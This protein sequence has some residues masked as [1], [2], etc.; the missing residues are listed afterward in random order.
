MRLVTENLQAIV[1]TT[2]IYFALPSFDILRVVKPWK[3]GDKF[4]DE[5]ERLIGGGVRIAGRIRG[6][7]IE[8]DLEVVVGLSFRDQLN[9]HYAQ[10]NYRPVWW[11][12]VARRIERWTRSAR[13]HPGFCLGG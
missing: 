2:K 6:Q 12:A 11:C 7:V 9:T 13:H 8:H 1:E 10:A 3:A 5:Q 4:R